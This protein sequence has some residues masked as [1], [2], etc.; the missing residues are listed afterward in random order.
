MAELPKEKTFG[1]LGLFYGEQLK[2]NQRGKDRGGKN[3]EKRSKKGSEMAVRVKI[4]NLLLAG[5]LFTGC[6]IAPTFRAHPYLD[7]KIRTTK[8]VMMIPPK[9]DVYQITAGGVKEK[10]DEW[11]SEARKNVI[12][13]IEEELSDRPGIVFKTLSEDSL[14]KE[15]EFNFEET[16]ALYGAIDES[17]II[18]TYGQP[19]N[20]FPEKIKDFDYSLGSEV[21][22][23]AEQADALLL[24]SCV[25]HISTEGR[26][27][28]M[29]TA[30]ILGVYFQGGVT[31][32]SV[33]LVDANSG[34][35]LWYNFKGS[36]GTHDLRDPESAKSLVKDLLKDFPISKQGG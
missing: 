19:K 26:K 23:L 18:H 8:T 12:T 30:A 33:A 32:V 22:G 15:V 17:I 9:V 1:K 16:L 31:A 28:L 20:R 10:M 7:E 13:A 2:K 11:T 4:L 14:S 34:S 29:F 24:V 6:A 35:V 36:G 5:L 21:K 25:D 3:K 27:A